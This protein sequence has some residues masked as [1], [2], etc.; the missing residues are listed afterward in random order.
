MRKVNVVL[1]DS[2]LV[3][4]EGL[5]SALE[6]TGSV[7][8]LADAETGQA[9]ALAAAAHKPAVL[10][11][12]ADIRHAPCVET[13]GRVMGRAGHPS[14]LVTVSL[15]DPG[16]INFM[17]RAGASGF[18]VKRAPVEEYT[19]AIT[20]VACG[21]SYFS[22]A[23]ASELFAAREGV[24]KGPNPFGLT[25]RELEVLR[26]ICRGFANKDIAQRCKLSV[27]TVETHRYNIR[28]KTNAPRLRDLIQ[29][30][31]QLGL[32]GSERQL[33]KPGAWPTR[34]GA[35][36]PSLAMDDHYAEGVFGPLISPHAFASSFR[37][38]S[39]SALQSDE[40]S[41]FA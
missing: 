14:V 22:G 31:R 23:I 29:V 35:P 12:D 6:H 26:L 8:V 9:A 41:D 30:G 32:L 11:L 25:G 17:A 18:I 34:P 19:R 4:R 28:R 36:M 27:R 1:A 3:V 10:I 16:E 13:I 5:R 20:A 21:G 7:T 37:S 24:T 2:H 38:R 15:L 40:E 33:G 39:G